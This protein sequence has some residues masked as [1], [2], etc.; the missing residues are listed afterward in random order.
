MQNHIRWNKYILN[1]ENRR[2]NIWIHNPLSKF[3]TVPSNTEDNLKRTYRISR[4]STKN[5]MKE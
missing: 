1:M 2:L 4:T 5:I 3:C